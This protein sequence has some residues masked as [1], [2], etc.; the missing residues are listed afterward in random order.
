MNP[1]HPVRLKNLLTTVRS[2]RTYKQPVTTLCRSKCRF[3]HYKRILIDGEVH[4]NCYTTVTL[5]DISCW[6]IASD[7]SLFPAKEK[8]PCLREVPLAPDRGHLISPLCHLVLHSTGLDVPIKLKSYCTE[9]LFASAKNW[10]RRIP[11]WKQFLIS[12]RI[13]LLKFNLCHLNLISKPK[14]CLPLA[15]MGLKLNNT[16]AM[17]AVGHCN[18]TS[19]KQDWL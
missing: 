4:R 3:L 18:R 16:P 19:L 11:H 12:I 10:T 1:Q 13:V 7:T 6:F 8:P 17:S 2:R 9:I 15:K 5:T 14:T